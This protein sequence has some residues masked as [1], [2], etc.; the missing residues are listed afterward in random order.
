MEKR[1]E[2]KQTNNR[3]L[4]L[5]AIVYFTL[6]L[7]FFLYATMG[8]DAII[9]FINSID[10]TAVGLVGGILLIAPLLIMIPF[11]SYHI[12][13]TFDDEK[14]S[15]QAKNKKDIVVKYS[16]IDK[17]CL[18][19]KRLNELELLNF[20]SKPLYSFRAVNDGMAIEKILAILTKEIIFR[21]TTTQV[22]RRIGTYPVITYKR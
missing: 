9:S 21:K 7:A 16:S 10:Y 2:F 15:V 13:V 19:R 22:K 1:V 5:L 20:H 4:R 14:L 12:A 3:R 18:N 8:T 17:M 11:T 6:L